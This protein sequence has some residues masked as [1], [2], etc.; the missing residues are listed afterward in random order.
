MAPPAPGLRAP[1]TGDAMGDA[2]WAYRPYCC[3]WGEKAGPPGE[4][5]PWWLPSSSPA[6]GREAKHGGPADVGDPEGSHESKPPMAKVGL[7]AAWL[8]SL[9]GNGKRSAGPEGIAIPSAYGS[10][11]L[12]LSDLQLPG[13]EG[14]CELSLSIVVVAED[15]GSRWD[16]VWSVSE[17]RGWP[18]GIRGKM[19]FTT[20]LEGCD[21]NAVSV[22]PFSSS[23]TSGVKS[24]EFRR[25]E[26][27]DQLK[28]SSLSSESDSKCTNVF[29]TG[30]RKV[31]P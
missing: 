25:V 19:R 21:S 29:F 11:S 7:S 24:S 17:I 8:P 20:G 27:H 3:A 18:C 9:G 28:V 6:L 10:L 14:R 22:R 30:V 16:T 26:G 2:G 31:S 4:A 1:W 23:G 12:S 5:C 13:G 15:S